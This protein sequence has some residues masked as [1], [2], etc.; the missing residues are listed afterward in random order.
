MKIGFDAGT[1]NLVCCKRNDKNE[2]VYKHEVNAF[3][4]MALEGNSFV[5]NMMKKAGVPLILREDVKTAYALGEAAVEM[6][7]TM[8]QIELKRPMKEGCVNP[9]EVNAFQIMNI[10]VH[11]LL[12][13]VNEDRSVLYYTVPAN[14]INT[15]TDA[16]YH[17]KILDA[18]FK[19][20]KSEAGFTIDA[21]PI[22]EALALVYAELANK[23]FTGL[24]AS[25]GAGM[26]NI[27]FAMF[28]APIFAFAL[29][30]SGDWIDQMA[31]R[32]TNESIAFIN[33][34]KK[35]VDLTKEPTNL[36]ERAIQTQYRLMIEK[37]VTGIKKGLE[38]N[39]NKA[40]T[41]NPID[42]VIAGGTSMPVGFDVLFRTV[43]QEAKLP[44]K[45]GEII[46]PS[47]PLFAVARGAL[48]AAENA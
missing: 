11:S 7:Y 33:K 26:V 38:D 28:G 36:V 35:K 27:C 9:K 45:I 6:A 23:N 46:R 16:E 48:V 47:D 31:A 32:A 3:L 20:Y 43:V 34:E 44:V 29:V 30:N 1:Y 19:A 21:R 13:N 42:F 14:A 12:E 15:Q 41:D 40:R 4:E 37:T 17:G 39:A 18:I 24:A 8:P 10:M 2:F 25:F 22:N 5:F